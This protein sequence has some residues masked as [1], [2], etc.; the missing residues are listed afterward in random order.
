YSLNDVANL[1]D[2]P[3]SYSYLDLEAEG[4]DCSVDVPNWPSNNYYT[5]EGS[6]H[7]PLM[8][9][10]INFLPVINESDYVSFYYSGKFTVFHS[11]N[12]N[13]TY[14]PT[15]QQVNR[16]SNPIRASKIFLLGLA[17]S[18]G[19]EFPA[20]A[21]AL[22]L[23][24]TYTDGSSSIWELG[25][26]YID[27]FWYAANQGNECISALSGKITEIDLGFQI[28]MPN[29]HIHTHTVGFEIDYFKYIQSITFVDPGND[30]SG[31]HLLA[32]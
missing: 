4:F 5:T 3:S 22:T 15:I 25:Y 8:D 2:L 21:F 1:D 6:E 20:G 9:E 14:Q 11:N 19:D 23:N 16:T 12:G 7:G 24:I 17:G 26:D 29:Q 10:Q 27:D 18:W 30:N 32:V 28:D 31:P 13:L